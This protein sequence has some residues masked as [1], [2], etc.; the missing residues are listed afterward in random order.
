MI[1]KHD[2]KKWILLQF[3][4]SWNLF[5]FNLLYYKEIMELVCVISFS[6][7][8]QT[9]DTSGTIQA[10]CNLSNGRINLHRWYIHKLFIRYSAQY[11]W[12]IKKHQTFPLKLTGRSNSV[13]GCLTLCIM[14]LCVSA[15]MCV[16][17]AMQCMLVFIFLASPFAWHQ[18]H[19]FNHSLDFSLHHWLC[20]HAHSIPDRNT[21]P[22][23]RC[24][25]AIRCLHTHC[26]LIWISYMY[27]QLISIPYV[28]TH[29]RLLLDTEIK[30]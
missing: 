10:Y 4:Y 26:F 2:R 11:W 13:S 21:S 22:C 14:L 18:L 9:A 3:L 16:W 25:F 6:F 8:F 27:N 17:F 15:C 28:H 5:T 23:L 19:V 12:S 30:G 20:S 7:L 1:Q 24:F 29:I